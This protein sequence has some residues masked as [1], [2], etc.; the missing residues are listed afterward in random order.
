MIEIYNTWFFRLFET[1]TCKVKKICEENW[2][3]KD[4]TFA[5]GLF[6]FIGKNKFVQIG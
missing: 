2:E 1:R 5:N 3:T 4:L 6:S